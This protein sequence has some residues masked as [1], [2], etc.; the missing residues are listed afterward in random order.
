MPDMWHVLICLIQFAG[1]A[2]TLAIVV[3]A[4]TEIFVASALIDIIGLRPWA[5][6]KALPKDG[7]YSQVYWYHRILHKLLTCGYCLSVWTAAICAWALPGGY[8]GLLLWDNILVKIF[9]L[10]RLSNWCHVYYELFRR[11]RVNSM[12]L[13]IKLFDARQQPEAI[14]ARESET[15]G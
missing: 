5:V 14:D 7:D 4:V 1:G 8:F 12:D 10:H 13:E 6:R 9:L 2:I 11:G 15:G 3:E